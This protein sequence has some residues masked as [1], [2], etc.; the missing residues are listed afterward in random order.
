M[1]DKEL[2]LEE[3]QSRLAVLQ[4]AERRDILDEYA[5]HIELR[6]A[7]GLTEAEAIRDFGDLDQLTAE[8]LEAYHVDPAF[9]KSA[10]KPMPDPRPALKKGE[11][12]VRHFLYITRCRTFVG[13]TNTNLGRVSG[14][15]RH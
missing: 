6:V 7:G 4:E 14:F 2:F 12:L 3:L 15:S 1:N 13:F 11:F 10:K 8:I 9:G 5:Q